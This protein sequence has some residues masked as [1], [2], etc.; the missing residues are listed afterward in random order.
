M[1]QLINKL[2]SMKATLVTVG[3]SKEIDTINEVIAY[4][5]KP[6]PERVVQAD[7]FKP[8]E[9][10]LPVTTKIEINNLNIYT[11]DTENLKNILDTPLP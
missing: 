11:T 6:L 9:Y 10:E 3:L 2:E 7:E 1:E 4:L 5:E 8:V